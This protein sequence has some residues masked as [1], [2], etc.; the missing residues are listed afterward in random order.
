MKK[1][2][3]I[4]VVVALIAAAVGV[5]VYLPG[6]DK[7]MEKGIASYIESLPGDLKADKIK[8]SYLDKHVS[9]EGLKGK[10][11]YFEGTQ[12]DVN[13][14]VLVL[15]GCHFTASTVKGVRTIADNWSVSNLKITTTS[16]PTKAMQ[17]ALKEMNMPAVTQSVSVK[18]AEG[19]SI[20]GDFLALDKIIQENLPMAQAIEALSSISLGDIKA[21]DYES[22]TE[23]ANQP[24]VMHVADFTGKEMSMRAAR[25]YVWN[26]LKMTLGGMD[27]LSIGKIS[28]ANMHMPDFTSPVIE[29]L[30]KGLG[31]DALIDKVISALKSEPLVIE[32]LVMEDV[33]CLVPMAA[34]TTLARHT[35]DVKA[36]DKTLQFKSGL[37]KLN[38]PVETYKNF[39][40][41]TAMFAAA[42]G[43]DLLLDSTLDFSLEKK[44]ESMRFSIAD[45]SLSDPSLAKV[46]YSGSFQPNGKG[47]DVG[48]IVESSSDVFL[49][50]ANLS[51]SDQGVIDLAF[52]LY[53]Q[54]EGKG[55]DEA[56][57]QKKRE[58]VAKQVEQAANNHPSQDV[59]KILGG[60]VQ[61]IL[62]P[63][64]QV[65]ITLTPEQPVAF[66]GDMDNLGATVTFKEKAAQ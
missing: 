52:K 34:G 24:L 16:Q 48:D 5:F 54:M 37:T 62:H 47:N 57:L 14:G 50:K 20:S 18:H 8:V 13:I 40:M 28:L 56:T 1:I 55:T 43:K 38:L 44:D 49:E 30:E 36:T 6:L 25:D 26:N 46:T 39:S 10:V 29:A 19:K 2:I 4:I 27:V 21:T 7:D 12:A 64:S 66:S 11:T 9:I 60:V 53:L 33:Q 59:K 58:E 61:L 41:E 3:G 35:M 65:D 31:E 42:Y 17:E 45:L 63:N 32:G 15:D 23:L 51:F 22:K